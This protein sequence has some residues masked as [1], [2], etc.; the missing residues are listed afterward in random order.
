MGGAFAGLASGMRRAP[1][2]NSDRKRF[3][4]RASPAG[5]EID[6]YRAVTIASIVATSAGRAAGTVTGAAAG[7]ADGAGVAAVESVCA[8][9]ARQPVPRKRAAP[10]SAA[11]RLRSLIP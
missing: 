10:K 6:A 4:S 11:P 2:A 3:Q 1:G 8:R 9:G 7:I 5:P